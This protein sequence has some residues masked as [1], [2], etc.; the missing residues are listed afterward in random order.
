MSRENIDAVRRFV[1]PYNRRDGR[2]RGARQKERG[3][4]AS[5]AQTPSSDDYRYVVGLGG[6]IP[7]VR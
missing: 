2:T 1:D 4:R 6:S 7:R 3:S 5:F